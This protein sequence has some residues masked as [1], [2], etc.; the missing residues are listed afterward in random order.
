MR[1]CLYLI[2]CAHDYK[3]STLYI[4][5]D[6]YILLYAFLHTSSYMRP[7]LILPF[8]SS[9]HLHLEAFIAIISLGLYYAF[10]LMHDYTC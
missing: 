1:S 5:V 4:C 8:S 10:L 3:I 6:A 2:I 9:T 7:F